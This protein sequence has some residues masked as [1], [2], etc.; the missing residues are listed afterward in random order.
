MLV[1]TEEMG[2]VQV[3]Y[4]FQANSNFSLLKKFFLHA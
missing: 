1:R 2:T 3:A 4:C